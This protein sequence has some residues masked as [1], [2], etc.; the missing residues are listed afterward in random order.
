MHAALHM[1]AIEATQIRTPCRIRCILG[2]GEIAR[3]YIASLAR[4]HTSTRSYRRPHPSPAINQSRS[5]RVV[6]K[7]YLFGALPSRPLCSTSRSGTYAC[8]RARRRQ[9]MGRTCGPATCI[10]VC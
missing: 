6:R 7:R 10:G 1:H 3:S 8:M 9:L 2:D 5:D 4:S